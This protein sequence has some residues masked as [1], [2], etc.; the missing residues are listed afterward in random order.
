MN[1]ATVLTI[2]TDGTHRDVCAALLTVAPDADVQRIDPGLVRRLPQGALLIVSDTSHARVARATGF[3]GPI[4]IVGAPATADEA[5]TFRAQGAAFVSPDC[6][7][8]ALAHALGDAAAATSSDSPA[9]SAAVARSRQLLAAGEIAFGLQHAF[10]NPLTALMAE[11]Q[12]LQMDAPTDEIR[13]TADRMLELVRRL[14]ELSKSLDAVRD[15]GAR[16]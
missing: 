7:P 3:D 15:R 14:T 13:A 12:L 1:T 9:L 8:V 16:R 2:T 6:D 4:L 11:V 10:N 5:A